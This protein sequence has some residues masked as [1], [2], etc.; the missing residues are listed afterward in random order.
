MRTEVREALLSLLKEGASFAHPLPN[1]SSTH[2]YGRQ[3]KLLLARAREQVAHS[4]NAPLDSSELVFTSSGTEANQLAIRSVLEPLLLQGKKPHWITSE[5]EHDSVLQMADWLVQRGGRVSFVPLS[6]DG[7]YLQSSLKNLI[8]EETAL[9]SLLWVNNETG[10]INDIPSLSS[11]ILPKGCILHVDAAQAWGKLPIDVRSLGALLV[12]VSGHKIGAPAGIGAL[13]VDSR[14]AFSPLLL[15]KQ[16]KAKRGGTENLLGAFLMGVA[17]QSLR[18][19]EWSGRVAPL[20]DRLQETLS[21]R[22]TG[23]AFPGC[24]SPRVANTLNLCFT[25]LE[26][27]NAIKSDSLVSALD[28]SGFSVSQGSAC[29]SGV[30]HSSRVLRAMG[31]SPEQAGSAIRISLVDE[32]SWTDLERFVEELERIVKRLRQPRKKTLCAANERR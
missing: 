8:T 3:A 23:V 31:F 17:A 25:G 30:A 9:V 1:P 15:G 19:L 10:V 24:T 21:T 29:S 27:E 20:R 12:S 28:L 18:P 22:I 4:L 14:L 13:W 16:E 6:P 2:S 11:G 7:T 32:L 5:A 26:G